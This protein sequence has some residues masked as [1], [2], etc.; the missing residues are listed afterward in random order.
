MQGVDERGSKAL[1]ERTRAAK[2]IWNY[3][4]RV[5]FIRKLTCTKLA[6]SS[7][8]LDL[9]RY[10]DIA[11][12]WF[13]DSGFESFM[14]ALNRDQR[15]QPRKPRLVFLPVRAK[16]GIAVD[17]ILAILTRSIIALFKSRI[18]SRPSGL[19]KVIFTSQDVE[20]RAIRDDKTHQLRRS[21]AFFDSILR[22]LIGECDCKG[23]FPLVIGRRHRLL[24]YEATHSFRIL[25]DK[26]RN[27]NVTQIPFEFYW[28][29][30]TRRKEIDAFFHF[31][32][33]WSML[34]RDQ[35]FKQICWDNVKENAPQ[36]WARVQYYF[37]VMF[38]YVAGLIEM[39]GQMIQYEK[40]NLV[41]IVNEYGVFE[42]ALVVAAKQWGVPTVALQHGVIHSKH[43]GYMHSKSEIS[44]NGDVKAPYC[45]IPDR[46]AVYGP[47]HKHL[48]TRLSAYPAERVIV[49]GQPRYDRMAHMK[50]L[51]SRERFLQRHSIDP[52]HKVILWTTQCHGLS[53]EENHRN[54]TTVLETISRLDKL[55]LVIKQHPGEGPTYTRMIQNYLANQSVNA[56]ITPGNSDVYE[57]LFACDLLISKSSTT[58]IEAA[59]LGK[60]VVLLNLSGEPMPIGLDYVKEG[61]AV[62]ASTTEELGS[63]IQELLTDDR[64]LA[65]NRMRFVKKYLYKLDAKATERVVNLIWET[66]WNSAKPPCPPK[67]RARRYS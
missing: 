7:T 11:L 53:M 44:P 52:D 9:T 35:V 23:V 12:W 57:Q 16:I 28:S 1:F 62:N 29:L 66:M 41:L 21:D 36:V 47:F 14:M 45:P 38:P 26:L 2:E 24:S 50:H 67:L 18:G 17:S 58:V 30:G 19:P 61:I 13:V 6:C 48:L 15:E 60:P 55:T 43:R 51:Y 33:M 49:T 64:K 65:R 27:W 8:L 34:A 42:R 63:A 3:E 59:A 10:D 22:K 31:K 32:T 20:W 40:P 5:R 4:Q 25:V 56:V 39:A 37:L 54:F 46:T